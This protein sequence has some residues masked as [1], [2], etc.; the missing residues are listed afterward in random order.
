MCVFKDDRDQE[1]NLSSERTPSI[2]CPVLS[3]RGG[4]IDECNKIFEGSF[5]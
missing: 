3:K 1:K 5:S 4:E 2:P